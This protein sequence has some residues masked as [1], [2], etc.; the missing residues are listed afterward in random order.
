MRVLTITASDSS[1][2]GASRVAMDIH[3]G[4]RSLGHQSTVFSGKKY[5]TDPD[6]L[7]IRRPYWAKALSWVLANDFEIFKTDYLLETSEFK[8]ADII[9]C[10]NLN[11]WYFSLKTLVKM[12]QKKPVV[13]TLHDMWAVTPHG[14]HTSSSELRNGIYKTSDTSLYPTT[15]WN[16]DLYLSWRKCHLYKNLNI[17]LVSPSLWLTNIINKT[18][19]S[20]KKITIIP[21][22]VD[23]DQFHISD[24]SKSRI[25]HK[26]SSE[27]LVLFIGADAINNVYKGY[28][29]FEWMAKKGPE[30]GK[31]FQFVCLGASIDGFKSGVRLIR[32]SSDKKLISEILSCADVLVMPSKFENFPLVA[33]EAMACGVP[34]VSYDVGGT[35]ESIGKAPNCFLVEPANKN[36][37]WNKVVLA[38]EKSILSDDELRCNLRLY[39]EGKFSLPPMMD[40]YINL[41]NQC[42][43][44]MSK[45]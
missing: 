18:C 2:G 25:K 36:Q 9:H 37:L 35:K 34:V 12:S 1:S 45:F 44:S 14:A 30:E 20:S 13:W 21:N 19:L 40:S 33:L 42:I 15:L 7:E 27:P 17:H 28:Q 38:V 31:R 3:Q 43:S 39:A 4:L 22:G 5:S 10:H 24:K 16:N 29:D 32:A 26:F 41:Y 23:F 8:S 6:V 11:G